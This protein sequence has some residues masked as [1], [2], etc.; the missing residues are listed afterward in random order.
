MPSIV[1]GT[2]P[3]LRQWSVC[4]MLI[5]LLRDIISTAFTTAAFTGTNS[6]KT[7][8]T[9][10]ITTTTDAST[11]ATDCTTNTTVS[12]CLFLSPY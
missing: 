3:D 8:I 4:L 11:I 10:T 2:L 9:R 12:H 6:F 1:L 7:I 5:L